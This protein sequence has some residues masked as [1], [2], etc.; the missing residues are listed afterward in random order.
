[1]YTH[2]SKRW[3]CEKIS[4]DVSNAD[5]ERIFTL[6]MHN[7]NPHVIVAH[8]ATMSHG[9]TLTAASTIVWYGPPLS[10]E[11]YE[12]ANGRITR[13]GQRHA[14]LIVHIAA[15]KLEQKIYTRLQARS[16]TQG[17]LLDMFEAQE[18]GAL[19]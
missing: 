9:L 7:E 18:L 8:P 11:M 3:S 14:Q 6:F 15:T 4:G 12:Q 5:R 1:L 16:A 2:I 19:L 13:A 17:L 10:L